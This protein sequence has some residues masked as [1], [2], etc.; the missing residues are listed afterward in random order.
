V[1]ES[2]FFVEDGRCYSSPGVTAGIDLMLHVLSK[3]TD[4]R[5]PDEVA[6]HL[7]VYIRRTGG[8]PQ[9]SP[10]LEGCNH[11]HPAFHRAQNAIAGDP[12]RDWRLK[13]LAKSAGASPRHLSRLFHECADRNIPDYRNR[14]R[15]VLARD[16]LAQTQLDMERVAERSGFASAQQLRRVWGKLHTTSPRQAREVYSAL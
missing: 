5:C 16:L 2:R 3:I 9:L 4:H 1:L 10:W 7:V 11:I 13:A 14:L 12:A 8:D 15:I 6:R